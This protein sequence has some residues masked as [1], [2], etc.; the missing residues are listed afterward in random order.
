[1]QKRAHFIGICGVGISA[2][3]KLLKNLGWEISGSDEICHAPVSES[4]ERHGISVTKGFKKENIPGNADII[5][6]GRTARVAPELNEETRAAAESGV[7]IRSFPEILGELMNTSGN[8]VVAGS[9]GKSTCAALLAWCLKRAGKDPSFFIGAQ[10]LRQSPPNEG[11]GSRE[12]GKPLE[13]PD[14]AHIGADEI[15]IFEGDEYPTSYSNPD[16]KFLYY[17]P[18]DVLL[19]SAEHDHANVFPT[20]E[21]YLLPFRKLLALMPNKGLLIS[22]ADETW[23]CSLSKQSHTRTVTYGIRAENA[24]WQAQKIKISP[25]ETT[26][27]LVHNS[28]HVG[29][30]TTPLFGKHNV[31]NIVGVSAIILE[32]GLLSFEELRK[33]VASFRGI[34]RRLE[35]KQCNSSVLLYEGFGSSRA[36]ARSALDTMRSYFPEKHLVV[37]FEPHALSWRDKAMLHWYDN[38]FKPEENIVVY[39]NPPTQKKGGRK[40]SSLNEIVKR[41]ENNGAETTGTQT[42]EQILE[43][44]KK[45]LTGKEVV[46]VLTSG[47]LGGALDK[48]PKL[49]EKNFSKKK[50]EN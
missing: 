39:S 27:N 6:I 40:Q 26:F 49:L 1:M 2:T 4:L 21:E 38:L 37:V 33:G 30:L 35:K 25:Q 16:P 45:T 10:P 8:I 11:Q 18:H 50:S 14:G 7:S 44:F 13:M 20:Q 41:I 42:P 15:S 24:D 32:K 19:T 12:Q 31:Q 34:A 23:A 9:Y 3:A 47:N 48:I 28:T 17:N 22:C 43:I 5:V 36:K 29:A 46:L